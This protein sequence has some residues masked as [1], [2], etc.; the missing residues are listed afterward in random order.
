MILCIEGMEGML[1][2]EEI[3]QVLQQSHSFD[4]LFSIIFFVLDGISR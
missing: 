1:A 4:M 2:A 3:L